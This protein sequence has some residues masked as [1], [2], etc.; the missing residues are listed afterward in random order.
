[1]DR[2]TD[3]AHGIG[4]AAG[5]GVPSASGAGMIQLIPN[6]LFGSAAKSGLRMTFRFIWV[7]LP[8]DLPVSV[9]A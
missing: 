6:N 4:W 5:R 2:G 3:R 9:Q 1:M 8:S 7:P